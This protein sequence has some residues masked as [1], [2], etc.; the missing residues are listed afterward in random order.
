MYYSVSLGKPGLFEESSQEG[1]EQSSN[2]DAA[3]I[4]SAS[5]WTST[6]LSK[7]PV[8]DDTSA[9]PQG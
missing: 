3:Q 6:P 9:T 4:N 1:R 5:F 2:Q 7:R 8:R